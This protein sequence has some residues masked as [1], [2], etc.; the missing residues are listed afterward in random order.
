MHLI[1]HLP[2]GDSATTFAWRLIDRE[3]RLPR[4][5]NAAL[6][7]I[8]RAD[9]VTLTIPANHVLFT[10]LKLPPVSAGKLATLLPFAIEDKLMSDPGDIVALAGPARADGE[11]V[12]AVV[13]RPWLNRMLS[14]IQAARIQ[15]DAAV[16]LSELVPRST[17]QWTALLPPGQREGVLVRDDGFAIAFDVSTDAE[18]PLAVVLAL[19]EAAERAPKSIQALAAQES[20]VAGWSA[21]LNVPVSWRAPVLKLDRSSDFNFLNHGEL[22][23]YA[24]RSE[25]QNTLPL[26]KPAGWAVA[27]LGGFMLVSIALEVWQLNRREQ[28][29]RAEM[30]GLFQTAFP[31]AKAIVDPALQMARNVEQ[32][33]RERGEASE[34]VVATLARLQDWLAPAQGRVITLRIENQKLIA[35]LQFPGTPDRASLP[36]GWRFVPKNGGGT[37][38]AE[39]GK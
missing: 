7:D 38:T 27:A 10:E 5:G 25:F 9:K 16:P 20:D 14:L 12:V 17:G 35:E 18:P 28:A 31:E 3:G 32:L 23:R 6:V 34:P 29:L 36:A 1:L 4:E 11:R 19:K 13:D 30:A 26:F 39:I 8:P 33:K 2:P 24:R 15:P 37:L 21:R 22:R